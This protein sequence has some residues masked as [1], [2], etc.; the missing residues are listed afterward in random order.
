MA[1]NL[2]CP[3][4]GCPKQFRSQN[5]RTYHVRSIHSNNNLHD[6]PLS[7]TVPN[8]K[9]EHIPSAQWERSGPEAPPRAHLLKTK[10]PHLS[11]IPCNAA[12][13]HIDPTL[14]P[15]PRLD[16][17]GS[18]WEPYADEIQFRLAD[19]T[20]MSTTNIDELMEIWAL[21]MAK[22]G[23]LGP[24]SSY[25][26]MYSTIDAT[27]LGDAPWQS[28]TA[29]FSGE[30]SSE[31][32]TWRTSEYEV[33]Y[34][35]PN[36]VIRNML[37]NPDFNGQFDYAPYIEL[38]KSGQQCWNDFMS[39]NFAW[40]HCNEIFEA[41]PSVEG[42]MYCPIILGSDKTTVS[43]AT[44]NVEYHPL[45][46]S[47][48]NVH[49]TVR[50][51]HRN[52][53]VPIGFLA[54]PKGDR[55][56]D[57][58][59]AFQK[60]KRQLYHAS[61]SAILESLCSGMTT[62]V[63]RR[64]LYDL[65]SYI[66]D[67]PE[68]VLLAGVV[69]HWC[70]RCTALVGNLDGPEVLLDRL[71]ST[72]L[73]NE[74]G[75]D[76]D[77]RPFTFDF[78]R[79][80]IHEMLTPDLLHQLIKGAFKDHL[81]TIAASPSFPGL[82]N[83]PHGRRFKQWTGDDSKALMKVYLPAIAGHVPDEMVQAIASF[84]DACYIVRCADI[85]EATL[86]T[87]DTTLKKFHLHHE[88]LRTTGVCPTG[89]SLPRQ[90]SLSHYRHLIEEFGTP[91]GL[92]SSITESRHITA[93]KRPWRRSNRYDALRQMLLTNQ[94]LDKLA[95]ARVDFVDRGMLPSTYPPPPQPP[96]PLQDPN[97]DDSNGGD[98][99]DWVGAIDDAYVVGNVTL[100]CTHH[101]II[102][103]ERNYPR[104][105]SDLATTL[106]LPELPELCRQFLYDQ[107][108]QNNPELSSADIPL[109]ECPKISSKIS[110]FHSAIA[111]FYAPS[112]ESGVRG[113]RTERIRATPSWRGKGSKYD[114]A[115]VVEDED[116]PGMKGMSAVRAKLFFSFKHQGKMYPCT[117]VDW[118]KTFG[119]SPDPIT[120]MWRV[121]PH[122]SHGS[123]LSTVVHLDS[124][125]RGV[126]LLPIFG[127]HFLPIR[128]PSS[129]SLD[130]FA[131]YYVNR[132]ADHHSHE[133]IF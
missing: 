22:H 46:L 64:F 77:V 57:G 40:R 133:I 114:C 58:D 122:M 91:G 18:E 128:F 44:G 34:R 111:K 1:R 26:H 56:Y 120:G 43:V 16:D 60:F 116:K 118:F 54:I 104:H 117:L 106:N 59:I 93:V 126:H 27:R 113:M 4:S 103:I 119:R 42:A 33:L 101:L 68:Q 97:N 115:L 73:W 39:G 35:N 8:G 87:F 125:L 107:L 80:D 2:P 5:G 13:K 50:R 112:D 67:Y 109:T 47:I 130:A 45:Y 74:Y 81:V 12:G 28:F 11:G 95:A 71:S 72:E 15:K 24:F 69:Q 48:G 52:A 105:L 7:G 65:A 25:E 88:I 121:K 21:S 92:C 36:T 85:T 79:A 96:P 108:H 3:V 132:Y 86:S 89:F 75:I 78:P 14:P 124:F 38:D 76:D 31:S 123:R 100:A 63:V 20:E 6:E 51:T 41:D 84:L 110:V 10:H 9:D 30:T 17:D 98:E 19:F 102:P 70:P 53:V 127:P 55:K 82:R 61:I 29:S 32:P 49:N 129:Y 23:D 90:H 66:A 37:N 99:R 62:P 83:F 131:G 94:R